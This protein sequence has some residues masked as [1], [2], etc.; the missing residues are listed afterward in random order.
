MDLKL[1]GAHSMLLREYANT[2]YLCNCCGHSIERYTIPDYVRNNKT[3][4]LHSHDV[5]VAMQPPYSG[6]NSGDSIAHS[7]ETIAAT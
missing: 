6:I 4:F 5:F 1:C 3:D 7:S 2:N